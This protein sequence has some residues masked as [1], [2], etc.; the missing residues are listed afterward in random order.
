[1]IIAFTG[2]RP[3]KIG[4]YRPCERHDL[5]KQAIKGYLL[6]NMPE[7]VIVG[8][9]LGVDQIACEAAL[10]LKIPVQAAI[11]FEGQEKKWPFESQMKY[12]KLLEQCKDI[13][14]VCPGEYAAWKMQA[15]N[16][17]MVDNCD[18]LIAIWDGSSGGTAN[19]VKY[20]QSK[21]KQTIIHNPNEF[22]GTKS[23]V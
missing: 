4:G 9:A 3:D 10:E 8:M 2:H 19:C 20:A 23:L 11:P 14:T 18:V 7:K 17:W 22:K 16:E 12:I 21:N 15:R 1:M 13:Y 5:I 6:M